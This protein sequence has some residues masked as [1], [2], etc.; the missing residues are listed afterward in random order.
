V[1]TWRTSSSSTGPRESRSTRRA[2]L[3]DARHFLLA[4]VVDLHVELDKEQPAKFDAELLTE[5]NKEVR[6]MVITWEEHLA[7]READEL[8]FEP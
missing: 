2:D 7:D 4:E 3:D 6:E 8:V 1:S 5:G